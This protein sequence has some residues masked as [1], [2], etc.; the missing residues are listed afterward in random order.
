MSSSE[1]RLIRKRTSILPEEIQ[2]K[3]ERH[4]ECLTTTRI[5]HQAH[6]QLNSTS[7]QTI[8][9]SRHDEDQKFGSPTKSKPHSVSDFPLEESHESDDRITAFMSNEGCRPL[10]DDAQVWQVQ[11][12]VNSYLRPPNAEALRAHGPTCRGRSGGRHSL[13]ARDKTTDSRRR[14]ISRRTRDCVNSASDALLCLEAAAFQREADRSTIDLRGLSPQL[15]MGR[16][17]ARQALLRVSCDSDPLVGDKG[18]TQHALR[19]KFETVAIC[20][21]LAPDERV[22][23]V[24]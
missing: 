12:Q 22:G 15:R 21:G 19:A 8:R 20:L 24:V 9:R 17:Y 11:P 13:R 10:T 6:S 7:V 1:A 14:R 5:T 18:V 2:S 23:R 4:H 3:K 16:A